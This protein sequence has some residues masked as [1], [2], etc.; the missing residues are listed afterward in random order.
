MRTQHRRRRQMMAPAQAS[1]D[2]TDAS[3]CGREVVQRSSQPQT[4]HT[5]RH[6]VFLLP[7]GVEEI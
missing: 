7:Q 4:L 2:C 3:T 6:T 1:C 5:F